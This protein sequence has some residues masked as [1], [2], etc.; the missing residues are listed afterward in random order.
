MIVQRPRDDRG[1]APAG[2]NTATIPRSMLSVSSSV[3]PCRRRGFT[4][5]PGRNR[6]E[7]FATRAY[8]GCGR[9]LSGLFSRAK[10]LPARVN[11]G[12]CA[13][14]LTREKSGISISMIF[15]PLSLAASTRSWVVWPPPNAKSISAELPASMRAF[16]SSKVSRM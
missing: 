16:L 8:Q 3:T 4:G 13:E 1:D 6:S 11:H 5:A 15:R 10:T 9:I 7:V 2:K 14:T 12:A